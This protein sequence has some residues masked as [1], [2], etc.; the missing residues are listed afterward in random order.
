[1]AEIEFRSQPAKWKG[2]ALVRD[3]DGIPK[4][5]GNWEDQPQQLKD[6]LTDDEYLTIFKTKRI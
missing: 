1:M 6:M 2:Y 5:D 3:K 4:C